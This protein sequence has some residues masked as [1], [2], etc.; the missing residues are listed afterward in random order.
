MHFDA[1][2]QTM[3][4]FLKK[5]QTWLF[6]SAFLLILAGMFLAWSGLNRQ[7]TIILDGEETVVRTSSLSI[8]GIL[9]SA[10]IRTGEEDLVLTDPE[11]SILRVDTILVERAR[12]VL[13]KTP[14]DEFSI[15]T[16][17][18]IP[19]NFLQS[20]GIDLYPEDQVLV[21]GAIVD[22]YTPI[23]ERGALM[24]QYR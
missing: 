19:A 7:V 11:A 6:P 17:E 2:K 14:N 18:T 20:I 22:P 23:E 1:Q 12:D 5:H 24:I 10:G 15:E 8:P 4:A 21:N 16:I 13:I 9:S 3:K